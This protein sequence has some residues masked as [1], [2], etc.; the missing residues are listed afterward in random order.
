MPQS[1]DT[2]ARAAGDVIV[3]ATRMQD[4]ALYPGLHINWSVPPER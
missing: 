2:A 3:V 4:F 1:I